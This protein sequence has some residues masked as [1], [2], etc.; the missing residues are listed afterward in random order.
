MIATLQQAFRTALSMPFG[1]DWNVREDVAFETFN[2]VFGL[3]TSR[4]SIFLGGDRIR[5]YLT[6]QHDGLLWVI[7]SD[8]H[9][10]KP[11]LVSEILA[12]TFGNATKHLI[13]STDHA[14]NVVSLRVGDALKERLAV[15]NLYLATLTNT[16]RYQTS[17]YPLNVARLAQWARFHHSARVH[18]V[19]LA[20]TFDGDLDRLATDVRRV[21][22]S[23]LGISV[24]FGEL[25]SFE[26]LVGL[27]RE[28]GPTTPIIC[29]GNVLAAWAC[30]DVE[31]ICSGLDTVISTS[32]GELVIEKV[33]HETGRHQ[34]LHPVS[35]VSNPRTAHKFNAPYPSAIV[36][37]DES[38]LL[39]TIKRS[40]QPAIE[41]SFGCQYSRCTFCPRDHRSKG[42]HRPAVEDAVAVVDAM[43]CDIA[44]CDNR[45]SVL[46]IVDEDAFGAEGTNLS[47]VE[48]SIIKLVAAASR[49][50]IA[51]EIYTRA[52]QLFNIQWRQTHAVNRV[53][54]LAELRPFLTRVFVGVESGAESQLRRYGKGQTVQDIIYALRL[55]SLLGLPLE[56]GFITFD[57]LLNE[58]ELVENVRF[59]ARTDAL[60]PSLK[61]CDTE[62]LLRQ[63]TSPATMTGE[64]IFRSVAYMATEL[65]VFAGSDLATRLRLQNSSL[66]KSYDSSFARYHY[67]FADPRI[68]QIAA[69]CRVW[70][71][72]TF[73]P[74][75][76]IR[77]LS[78]AERSQGMIYKA[79]IRRYREATFALLFCLTTKLLSPNAALLAEAFLT[80]D[81]R[82]LE[83]FA[84]TE[85]TDHVLRSVWSWVIEGCDTV[86]LNEAQFN[87]ANLQRRRQ[88]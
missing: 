58:R 84:E 74:V 14:I 52:E 24:N 85:I 53:R 38:L 19:D 2:E 43:A 40:G 13:S 61:A 59:L 36:Y 3:P 65:E 6:L 57:P 88:T 35:G 17:R 68:G 34:Q 32:Y 79:T 70:T 80:I 21:C 73:A 56:F 12:G 39:Q 25:S 10:S 8:S 30:S 45:K 27:I 71:E 44:N 72:G 81:R 76:R 46:S 15:P 37:P 26:T 63:V 54:Q 77:V 5:P 83:C 33:C 51:C 48:P 11:K 23:I 82:L 87:L 60:L 4:E 47:C 66:I 29:V 50:G 18:V 75:Y 9:L 20:L 67:D 16:E 7:A 86:H 31:R 1:T 41:T 49:H 78:R 22:P 69:W 42:W 28:D 64:P 55:G 62:E